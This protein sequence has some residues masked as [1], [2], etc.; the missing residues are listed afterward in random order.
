M[1][2]LFK[3][4]EAVGSVRAVDLAPLAER[5]RPV[6]FDAVMGQ[7]ALCGEGGAL[8]QMLEAG[9]LSSLILWGPPGCGK[10]S[11]ARLL[12]GCEG[13]AYAQVSAIYAG[14]KD[15][16]AAFEAA[17]VRFRKGVRTVLFVD[18][19]HRFNSAQQDAFLPVME[20][21]TII[22]VGATTENPSFSLNAALLSR[23]Q[24]LVLKALDAQALEALLARSEAVMG[25]D[26]PVT[27]EARAALI[28]MADGDGR[29]VIAMAEQL[30]SRAES[31]GVLDVE[32]LSA[33]LQKRAPLYDRAQDTH[34]NC[35]SAFHKAL[36]GSDVDGALYWMARMVE[37]G[38]DPA[39]IF[40]RMLAMASED[41]GNA[42]PQ[43]LV[44]ALSAWQ[45]YERLGPPEGYLALSQAV[46][47]L[48]AA[49][50]SNASYKA[51]KAARALAKRT[52]A[53]QPPMHAVN[54]PTNLMKDL[55][56][57]AGYAYDHEAEDGC[58]GLSYFPDTVPRDV[59]YAPEE[60]GFERE[61]RKRLEF[62][63]KKRS[64]SA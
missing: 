9:A 61:M 44:L 50:K 16:R 52:G 17:R 4:D 37:G 14:V 19:I 31:G 62:F 39:S 27:A 56:Y 48:A 49:P 34:Y 58:A 18:E 42:D 64:S 36:R 21:G 60:R 13:L 8:R 5:M 53:E 54:A 43:A 24:V 57:S 3:T 55:G 38:E 11:V 47:Y 28:D 46:V 26:L 20:D 41:I 12:A 45:A 10:T 2:D 63:E 22:L 40:R 15:L 23:A 33:V 30:Y 35:L 59:F 32:A 51:M 1:D 6:A 25:Q 7:D 29:Y